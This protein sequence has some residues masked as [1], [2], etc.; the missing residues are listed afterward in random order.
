MGVHIG[1]TWQIRLNDCALQLWVGLPLCG[2]DVAC[3]QISFGNFI[4]NGRK[5]TQWCK[6][7]QDHSR[8]S[9]RHL[10]TRTKIDENNS[11]WTVVC[12]CCRRPAS[13]TGVRENP[14]KVKL[15]TSQLMKSNAER[16]R[17]AAEIKT[18]KEDLQKCMDSK[19]RPRARSPPVRS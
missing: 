6:Q 16:N 17:M 11:E 19:P 2:G 18:L 7:D 5:W 15:L 1:T 14:A 10:K 9:L 4:G 8:L 3:S 13:A 12:W